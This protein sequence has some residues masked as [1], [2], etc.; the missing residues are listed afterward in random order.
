MSAR[1][2]SAAF[3]T[4]GLEGYFAVA[5]RQGRP[6][7]RRIPGHVKAGGG[8]GAT[9]DLSFYT[10]EPVSLPVPD[11]AIHQEPARTWRPRRRRW[12]HIARDE[13]APDVL[14]ITVTWPQLRRPPR[15]YLP[16]GPLSAR[17]CFFVDDVIWWDSGWRVL[18]SAA[19]RL[20]VLDVGI[21]TRGQV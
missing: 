1:F 3:P 10:G 4:E 2:L 19:D 17:V 8:R 5:D 11:E 20:D 7:G 21:P 9:L 6:V 12:L 16:P 18:V 15:R 14:H 13:D